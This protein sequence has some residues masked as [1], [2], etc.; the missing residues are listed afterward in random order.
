MRLT[1]KFPNRLRDRLSAVACAEHRAPKQQ[2]EYWIAQRLELTDG[3]LP[4][5][6]NDGAEAGGRKGNP[7]GLPADSGGRLGRAKG[8]AVRKAV[9]R[10]TVDKRVCLGQDGR[11]ASVQTSAHMLS[12]GD[13][14][15]GGLPPFAQGRPWLRRGSKTRQIGHR[16]WYDP[17]TDYEYEPDPNPMRR[18][19]HEIDWHR[20][21]YRDVDPESGKPVTG[22]EGKWRPL[23]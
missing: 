18:S 19:W 9:G 3:E 15:L 6:S 13:G 12:I 1:I 14:H 5:P 20:D 23:L 17:T 10:D 21:Q 11:L 8:E 7:G 2:I 4:A 16:V 22:S